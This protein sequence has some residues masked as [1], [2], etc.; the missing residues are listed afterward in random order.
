MAAAATSHKPTLL[1]TVVLF[2]F[3][4]SVFV[5]SMSLTLRLVINLSISRNKYP[6]LA[7]YPESLAKNTKCHTVVK[8]VIQIGKVPL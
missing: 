3:S 6:K 1:F 4:F 5:K 2:N 7:T 8:Q